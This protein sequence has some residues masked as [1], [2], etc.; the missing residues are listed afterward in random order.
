VDSEGL[1]ILLAENARVVLPLACTFLSG[2]LARERIEV[3]LG[4]CTVT[5]P[6]CGRERADGWLM[7][8]LQTLSLVEPLAELILVLLQSACRTKRPVD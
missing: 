7:V 1:E 6:K 4:V 8:V 3:E 2:D 5:P